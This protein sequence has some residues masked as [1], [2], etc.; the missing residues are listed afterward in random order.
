MVC[1]G[2]AVR[3]AD[4]ETGN[5]RTLCERCVVY[6]EGRRSEPVARDEAVACASC[7]RFV[8]ERHQARCDVDGKV[9]CS[10]H[11]ARTERSRRLVCETDRATCE[12]EPEAIVAADEVR[13]C[14]TCDRASC[15]EHA[16][17][18]AADG[19]WHCLEHLTPL[20]GRLGEYACARHRGA[21]EPEHR[22]P[23]R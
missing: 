5:E 17:A 16:A 11:L 22:D 18:C 13:R 3:S 7:E 12:H 14:E 8:C 15:T 21:L 9:H 6:C 1:G 19:A 23:R 2:H 10:A 20:E 4:A